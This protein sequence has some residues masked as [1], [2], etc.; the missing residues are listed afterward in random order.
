MGCTLCDLPTPDPPV[1]DDDVE[2]AY[3]CRGCLEVARTL[4][5]A[6]AAD[7]E[8][9]R[10][11]VAA[12]A[13]ESNVPDD[14]AEAFLSVEGMHCAT[15]EAFL[16]GTATDRDG[17]YAADASYPSEAV[18][19]RYD[20]DEVDRDGLAEVIDGLGYRARDPESTDAGDVSTSA[21]RT[22]A[23]ARLL[24]GGFF[25]MMSMTFYVLFLYPAYLGVD[26]ET[27]LLDLSG[28]TGLYVLGNVWVMASVVLFYTGYPILRGAYVSLRAR[29]PNMDLLVALAAVTAYTYSSLGLLLGRMELYY[30]VAIVIVMAVSLG[31]YYET[32]IRRRAADTLADLTEQRVDEARRRTDGG[33]E[34]VAVDALEPGEEVVVRPGDRIPVDGRIVEGQ[35]AVDES[36]VTGESLPVERGPGAEAVGGAVATDGALVVEVGE[37]ATSTVDRLIRHLWEVRSTKPGAQKI[38]DRIAAVF[39]PSVVTLAL[40][41]TAGHLALGASLAGALLTGLAVL[42]VSCPCALGLATPLAVAAG[43]RSALEQG[44]VITDGSVFE[45]AADADVVALDKTGTLT[46]GRMTVADVRTA[47]GADRATVLDRAAAV[48]TLSDHPVAAAI[49]DHAAPTGSEATGFE[50][51]PGRGVGGDVDGD[52]VV[53]GRRDLVTDRGWTVPEGLAA[54]Y[55]RARDRGGVPTLVAWGGRARGLVVAADRPREGW[56]SVVADLADGREVVVITGDRGGAADRFRECPDVDEVF[57]GV[58]PEAKGEVVQRLQSRGTVAMVGDGSNDAPA[59]AT[60]DLGIALES[61]TRLAADAADA[62]VTTGELSTVPAVFS[63]TAAARRRVRQNLGWAFLYNAIAVPLAVVGLINPLLAAAAMAASSLL[64]VANS[65]RGLGAGDA[66]DGSVTTEADPE[67]GE[68]AAAAD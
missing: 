6:A 64:V 29:R 21:S 47:E 15:C 51:H 19:L 40:V 4:D 31:D 46:T 56:E 52:R 33:T 36:L 32:R 53:V 20:P 16:E 48:E 35:A 41:A 37:D 65:A 30:D 58:P 43:V 38:A 67:V 1:T 66:D 25:A 55:D 10:N 18:K 39:V 23:A 27:L 14:A 62:V 63:V 2:G 5:D 3:C 34:V 17:V 7:A 24:V 42:V 61:G 28:T 45:T 68:A 49:V 12:D 22:D 50:R 9:A 44:V 8:R 54:R 59:L 11:E 60:A 57:A 13:D 26:P